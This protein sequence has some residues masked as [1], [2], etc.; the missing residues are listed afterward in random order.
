MAWRVN[1]SE[2]GDAAS[3]TLWQQNTACTCDRRG[4]D[5]PQACFFFEETCNLEQKYRQLD[6]TY[7][8]QRMSSL[9]RQ[10]LSGNR[11]KE[12]NT[13]ITEQEVPGTLSGL[14][15]RRAHI[16]KDTFAID[17]LSRGSPISAGESIA[18]P[19]KD[20]VT[21]RVHFPNRL[22]GQWHRCPEQ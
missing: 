3:R 12:P 16:A 18:N 8:I 6:G 7:T 21:R 2:L 9:V 19:M 1:G 14:V 10:C 15:L 17:M 20:L 4:K 11:E 22:F 5:T 13:G